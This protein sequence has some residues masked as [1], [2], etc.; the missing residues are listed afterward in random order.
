[1]QLTLVFVLPGTDENRNIVDQSDKATLKALNKIRKEC[2]AYMEV[3]KNLIEVYGR[4]L[5]SLSAAAQALRIFIAVNSRGLGCKM[6]PL[7]HRSTRVPG[8][9]ICLYP[10]EELGYVGF[11]D[12]WRGV[13]MP[14]VTGASIVKQ[15][16]D[17]RAPLSSRELIKAIEVLGQSIRPVPGQ[18]RMRI[19]FGILNTTTKKKGVDWYSATADFAAF[20]KTVAAR[21]TLHM[22]HRY[23]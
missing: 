9:S 7:M 15:D 16:L 17:V 21:G 13:A 2:C 10:T 5:S 6:Y 19:H 12:A 4:Q 3:Q 23:C 14:Q 8:P 11:R 1:M 22:H 18:L 20:L